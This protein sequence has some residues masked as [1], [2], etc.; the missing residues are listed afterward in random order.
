MLSRLPLLKKLVVVFFTLLVAVLCWLA[1]NRSDLPRVEATA[2]HAND[3]YGKLP[4]QFEPNEGQTA[5]DVEFLTRGS[6]YT[7]SLKKTEA[8]LS[9]NKVDV[10]LKL[11]G[12]NPAARI[13]GLDLL[14]GKVNHFI[15]NDPA[16]WRTNISTY[17]KGK[18]ERVY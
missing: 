12:S 14:P 3:A 2:A 17:R 10:R 11:L 6:S 9:L 4:L 1:L 16:K 18:D 5:A 13:G 15:G 7:M 8:V